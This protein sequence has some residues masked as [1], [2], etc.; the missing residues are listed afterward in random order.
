MV[1]LSA[2]GDKSV[3]EVIRSLKDFTDAASAKNDEKQWRTIVV[4]WSSTLEKLL[5]IDDPFQKAKA[6]RDFA[7]EAKNQARA[8]ESRPE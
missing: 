1:P 6:L 8:I 3:D 4:S 5:D 2:F 7:A